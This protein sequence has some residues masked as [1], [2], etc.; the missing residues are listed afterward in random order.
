MIFFVCLN[1]YSNLDKL[2][3]RN[4]TTSEEV[5]LIPPPLSSSIIVID[6][7]YLYGFGANPDTRVV[8]FI[9]DS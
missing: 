2:N 7:S 9:E 1:N 8:R 5:R 3:P 6:Q 4:P